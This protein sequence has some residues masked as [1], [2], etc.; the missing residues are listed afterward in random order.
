MLSYYGYELHY[1]YFANACQQTVKK[2]LRP[3]FIHLPIYRL[4]A[5]TDDALMRSN[6]Y[7]A[8]RC[9]S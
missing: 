1:R 8:I 3:S 6:L 2:T 4:L 9:S 5:A 7:E